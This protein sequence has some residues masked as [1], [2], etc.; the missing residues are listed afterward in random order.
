[1]IIKWKRF[2]LLIPIILIAILLSYLYLHYRDIKKN[3]TLMISEKATSLIG[4]RV[5]V[6]DISISLAGGINLYNIH[7]SNP[8]GFPTG[9][10]LRIKRL[11]LGISLNDLL[12][13]NFFF[14]N[15]VIH[16]P[17]LQLIKDDKGHWNISRIFL[18]S[19]SKKSNRRYR[20]EELRVESGFFKFNKDE[21]Y[22]TGPINLS[23]ENISSDPGTQTRIKGT[24]I[25]FGNR[26]DFNGR[27]F[28]ND[29][30]KKIN[31][32]ISSQGFALPFLKKFPLPYNI[33]MSKTRIDI[34]FQT[35]GEMERKFRILSKIRFR[36]VGFI[37]LKDKK[38]IYLITDATFY[39]SEDSLS[40]SSMSLE[41]DGITSAKIKGVIKNLRKKPF[42]SGECKIEKLDISQFNFNKPFKISGE[43]SS[44]YLKLEGELGKGIPEI[45][46]TI[47]WRN[48][49]IEF[50]KATLKEINGDIV[51]S[52]IKGIS[53]KGELRTSVERIENYNL[54]KPINLMVGV[55]FR[56]N[57]DEV[58]LRSVLNLSPIT[59]KLNNDKIAYL[60]HV[61]VT[62][63]GMVRG[64]AFSGKNSIEV[65]RL[66]YGGYS[67]SALKSSSD[68]YYIKDSISLRDLIFEIED[69]RSSIKELKLIIPRDNNFFTVEIKGIDTSF[70]NKRASIHQCDLYLNLLSK[71]G[72][73]S[74]AIR[75]S[76]E[77]FIFQD[78]SFGHING[79]GKFDE[80]NFFI[81]LSQAETLKGLIKI[82]AQGRFK[83]GP[84]PIK[85][86]ISAGGIDIGLIFEASKDILRLPYQINGIIKDATFEGRIDSPKS[87]HLQGILQADNLSLFSPKH[88][89]NFLKDGRLRAKLELKDEDISLKADMA[90][91]NISIELA[92]EIKG[93]KRGERKIEL[94]LKLPEVKAVEIR[95]AFW[96]VFPDNLLYTGLKGFISSSL[97]IGYGEGKLSL[98]G[99][100]RLRDFIIEG[101]NREYALGPVNGIL[102]IEYVEGSEDS[103]LTDI[104]SFEKSRFDLLYKNFSQERMRNGISRITI[105]SLTYGFKILDRI[106]IGIRQ[107]GRVLNI[108]YLGAN[109]FGGK[110][111]GSIIIDFLKG[112]HIRGG[113]L[114]KEISL[115]RLCDEIGSIKGYISGKVDGIATFK[116]RGTSINDF[117]GKADFWTYR[118]K[119]E[120]TV[121]SKSFLEKVGGTSLRGYIGDRNF[122]KG[123]MSL[124]LKDGYLIFEELEI[125][126]RNLFGIKDLSV[127][128]APYNNRIAINQLL[129]TITEASQRAKKKE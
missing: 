115:R 42:L 2:L 112:F 60:D 75:F 35:E 44:D 86:K 110:L 101:E 24:F 128:V 27:V 125:S 41:V 80:K 45:S 19:L 52:S 31:L 67:F 59:L 9:E 49:G 120:K 89:K 28:I 123:V 37:L 26:I 8:D 74:G 4:Q 78:I 107:N 7:I 15:I 84:F 122:D 10:L 56:S 121:I 102:P 118:T 81:D 53:A 98:R 38:D 111:R 3:F 46:G 119:D 57:Q 63:E 124:F 83:E 87:F 18:S 36:D 6:G 47:K 116:G 85:T 90:S 79:I 50:H 62:I 5:K 14:K 61:R 70:P 12:R 34:N 43:I 64:G 32:S 1:M 17:E 127:K 68:I 40:I 113:F 20:I 71:D 100:L 93:F 117:I 29:S 105:D 73:L 65:G 106:E 72:T 69:I 22:K 95:N 77:G 82:T 55:D 58:D 109:L 99:D 13:G 48:G 39:F 11:N 25:Y 21:R 51:F 97:S 76:A 108:E 54:L 66:A 129:W 91:K 103:P 33:D 114:V 92:G 88:G 30:P 104:P 126:N 94:K 16:S 23:L 96:D